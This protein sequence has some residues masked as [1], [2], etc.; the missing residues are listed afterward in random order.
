MDEDESGFSRW[1]KGGIAL[2]I[3]LLL[4]ALYFYFTGA[5]LRGLFGLGGTGKGEKVGIVDSVNGTLKR[6]PFD[7]LEFVIAAEKSDLFNEDTVM[8]GPTDTARLTLIDGS[9]LELEPG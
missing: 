9:V 2:L 5:S 8:T 6:Q 1:Q 3:L 7:S 4:G